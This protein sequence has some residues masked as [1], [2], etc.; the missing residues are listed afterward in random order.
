MS[1]L[2][3][4]G[5]TLNRDPSTAIT[6][7][8][9]R[10]DFANPIKFFRVKVVPQ[11]KTISRVINGPEKG[12]ECLSSECQIPMMSSLLTKAEAKKIRTLRFS[13]D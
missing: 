6:G 1:F 10:R 4:R 3:K 9:D 8:A 13:E 11:L 2:G 12:V 7:T 5:L